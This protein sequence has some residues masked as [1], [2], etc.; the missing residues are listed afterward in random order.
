MKPLV[1]IL[2]PAYNAEETVAQT[3]QSAIDQTWE[4]KE[5]IVVN[6][7][8]T[9]RTVEI[10]ERFAPAV[11][12]FSTENR[13]LSA[14]VNHALSHCNGDYIQELDSDDLLGPNKIERQLSTLRPGDSKKLLFSSPWAPFYY[15][16]HG[17]RF[18]NNSLCQD[19]TPVEWLLRK[20]SDNVHMQNATWLVSRELAEAAG[21][22]NSSLVYD[23]DGEYF[24]RVLIASEGTRF[25]PGPAVYYRMS[26][27][28]RISRIGKSAKKRESLLLSLRLQIQY[29]RSLEESERVREA[30]LTFLQNWYPEF[31]PDWPALV[32]E[33]DA[34]A[35]DLGGTVQSPPAS[36][37]YVWIG[38]VLGRATADW[39]R[40]NVP[41]FKSSLKR[42]W[43]K[44]LFKMSSGDVVGG[45]PRS[46]PSGQQDE[47]AHPAAGTGLR[48]A[49]RG[50]RG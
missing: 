24:A 17:V 11:R 23:Q 3:I 38:R 47:T 44:T 6:D 32:A 7:G 21:P 16:T 42:Q 26:G 9:D 20:F 35:A 28:Q 8:S 29:L 36:A 5:I 10:V 31:Y 27:P 19:L 48:N 4:R 50:S 34:L 46:S 2:I 40:G 33:I 22:W 37:K 45:V 15:R 39:A 14:A 25:V 18:V 49:D 12:L 43:D 13:G 1:S 41:E 30:C